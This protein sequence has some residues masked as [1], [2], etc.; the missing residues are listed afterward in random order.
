M[1]QLKMTKWH[2]YSPISSPQ[3]A[4]SAP[5]MSSSALSLPAF[6][7]PLQPHPS[8]APFILPPIVP[9]SLLRHLVE[10]ALTA[11]LNMPHLTAPMYAS[12]MS[13]QAP[14]RLVGE[15]RKRLHSSGLLCLSEAASG[16]VS[17][18]SGRVSPTSDGEHSDGSMSDVKR[19]KKTERADIGSFIHVYNPLEASRRGR[20]RG[21]PFAKAAEHARKSKATTASKPIVVS[22][23]ATPRVPD[24][25]RDMIR[26]V[27]SESETAA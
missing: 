3:A 18:T 16:R 6:L 5:G 20:P 9:G 10:P 4:F 12:L 19:I 24:F 17:P 14:A 8:P 23:P 7:P 2:S 22:P 25:M 11:D 26:Q 13:C 27:R 21:R 15:E 1:A